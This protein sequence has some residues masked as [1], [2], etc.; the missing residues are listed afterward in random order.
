MNDTFASLAH[1]GWARTLLFAIIFVALSVAV[2]WVIYAEFD[3]TL[4]SLDERLLSWR[5]AFTCISL[6][7]VYFS[8][9]GLRLFYTVKALGYDLPLAHVVKLVFINI[10]FSN[11]T[12][13]ATGGGFAQIWYMRRQGIHLGAATAAS[14]LRTLLASAMIFIPTPFLFLFLKPL[15]DNP[16][17][18]QWA[19]YLGIFALVYVTFFTIALIRVR[20]F[21][22][23][24]NTALSG[25]L[26]FRIIDPSRFRRWRFGIRRELIRFSSALGAYLRGPKPYVFASLV[27]TF[28]FLMTLFSF[29]AVLLWSLDYQIEYLTIIGLLI[30]T[31]FVMYFAPTPGA[32]GIAEG[33]FGLLFAP[34]VAIG[35][36]VL[37][38][39]IW[40]FLT[41]HLGMMIGLPVTLHLLA[42]KEPNGA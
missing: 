9:D 20:W 24:I 26:T 40:R 31:T 19:V 11:I 34:L 27:F 16:L 23:L 29:P 10:L 1:P 36:L 21:V 33:T 22:M 5:V 12:P 6:L 13:M 18:S 41:I 32:A 14:T 28:L 4:P 2:P 15:S 8:C 7:V 30:V 39:V 35:D 42:P 17:G 25:L 37:I 3:G 38:I